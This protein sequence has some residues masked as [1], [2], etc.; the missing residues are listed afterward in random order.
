MTI[1]ERTVR[2][3]RNKVNPLHQ[4]WTYAE[5]QLDYNGDFLKP[6]SRGPSLEFLY[7]NAIANINKYGIV[8]KLGS[9]IREINKVEIMKKLKIM[10]EKAKKKELSKDQFSV[11]HGAIKHLGNRH[12]GSMQERKIRLG[13]KSMM[14][15]WDHIKNINAVIVVKKFIYPY[16]VFLMYD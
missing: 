10:H 7:K 8:T 11:Y 4:Q 13:F 5:R 9:T 3:G 14:M 15:H 16:G 12:A 6:R 2:G 1:Q